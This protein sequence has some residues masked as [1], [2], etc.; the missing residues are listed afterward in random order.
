[1]KLKSPLIL[2]VTALLFSCSTNNPDTSPLTAH[3]NPFIGTS[4]HGKLREESDY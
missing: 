1:M 3:V 2:F 4:G